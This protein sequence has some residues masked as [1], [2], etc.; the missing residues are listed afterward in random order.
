MHGQEVVVAAVLDGA[1]AV[2][3]DK[4][5]AL[6]GLSIGDAANVH[7]RLDDVVEGVDVVVVQHEAAA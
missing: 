1:F 3:V 6:L 2:A 5:G 4:N 7:K